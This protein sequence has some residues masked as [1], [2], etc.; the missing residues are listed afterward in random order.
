MITPASLMPT[1]LMV[2]SALPKT[3]TYI[4]A[5]TTD[6]LTT[7]DKRTIDSTGAFLVGE[8][9]RLD[10]TVNEPLVN[11]KWSRDIQVREDVTIADETSSF[12]NSSFAATGGINPNGKNFIGKDTNAIAGVALD[13]GKTAQPLYLWGM[14]AAYTIPELESALRLGRPIDQQKIDV[15]HLK[16]QMD[17]DEMVYLGDTTLGVTGLFNNASVSTSNVVNGGGGTAWS[18]KTADQILTDVQSLLTTVWAN[19]G[20]AIC[21]SELRLPPIQFAQ[22]VS[23]KVSSAGNISVLQYLKDNSLA[24]QI[25]GTPLN[26][27]SSKWLP[28][29]GAGGTA[30]MV[31]Y[32]ND[33]SRVRYPMT[34][35]QRTP[36]E[37]RSIYQL[38]TYYGRIGVV[39]FVYPETCGYADGI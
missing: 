9:E 23:M 12:T 21:P 34:P 14:E 39:E 8:L 2:A 30:R 28:T 11:V 5:R 15:I 20:Y 22:I 26:I 10:P 6:G 7:Y 17:I 24:L 19:S 18:T 32:T 27:Q 4:R 35:L 33:R 36:P 37:Y 31:A 1:E 29:A 13:I 3:N 38:T 25:N 16:H